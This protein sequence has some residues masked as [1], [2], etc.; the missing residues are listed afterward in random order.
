MKSFHLIPGSRSFGVLYDGDTFAKA[1]FLT[2]R[3]AKFM[4]AF[5]GVREGQK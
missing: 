2:P 3:E 4:A 1:T 5:R